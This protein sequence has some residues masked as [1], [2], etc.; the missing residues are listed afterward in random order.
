MHFVITVVLFTVCLMSR[1]MICVLCQR[2]LF[3]PGVC[4]KC[5][6]IFLRHAK[7][8]TS[9]LLHLFR[10]YNLLYLYEECLKY[11]S[12]N[13]EAYQEEGEPITQQLLFNTVYMVEDLMDVW[14]LQDTPQSLI[15]I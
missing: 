9:Q 7:F 1:F 5:L 12:G 13:T 15:M 2:G 6:K 4:S 11:K 8:T 14:G 10:F 3:I